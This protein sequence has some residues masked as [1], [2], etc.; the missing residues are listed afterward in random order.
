MTDQEKIKIDYKSLDIKDLEGEEWRDIPD[1]EG[2]YQASNYG[3]IKSLDRTVGFKKHF[4]RKSIIIK[5]AKDIKGYLKVCLTNRNGKRNPYRLHRLIAKAFIPNP[6]NLPQINHKNFVK[7]DNRVWNLNWMTMEENIQHGLKNRKRKF[8]KKISNK[9]YDFSNKNITNFTNLD[10]YN[11]M[12]LK[13][14]ENEI[15]KDI[16]GY[17]K[18]DYQISNMGRVKSFKNNQVKI[19][20]GNIGN[21][22][23]Q[24]IQFIKNKVRKYF[25][26]HG[27]VGQYF[28]PNPN[29]FNSINHINGVK[30][31]NR[32]ENLEWCSSSYNTQHAYAI[33][34][35]RGRKGEKHH[36]CKLTEKDVLN[37]RKIYKKNV[38]GYIKIAK[39]Y[40]ICF[41]MVE[42]IIKRK[43]WTH[44]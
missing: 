12:D 9:K 35:H 37:I 14:L 24:I 6:N 44:I 22:G 28:I 15:W 42:C 21:R 38:F 25:K 4:F 31:D 17:Y 19:I 34:L 3:R 43:N 23:Y 7:N 2:L 20:H 18:F 41:Q 27:L 8:S 16:D 1:Y 32:V 36:N 40:G 33:G 13:N 29:N 26:V 5:A 39:L 10:I 30:T 11:E